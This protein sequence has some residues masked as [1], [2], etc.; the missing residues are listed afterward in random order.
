M[1]VC[2][3]CCASVVIPATVWCWCCS[4]NQC[5]DEVVL[6][7]MLQQYPSRVASE[8]QAGG[9]GKDW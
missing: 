9:C 2:V 4:W 8:I 6:Q 3:L 5:V 1:V 7:A